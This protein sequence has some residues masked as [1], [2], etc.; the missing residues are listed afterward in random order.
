M[1]VPKQCQYT[2]TI[3]YHAATVAKDDCNSISHTT[4]SSYNVAFTLL[5]LRLGVYCLPPPEIRWFFI[6]SNQQC[7]IEVRLCGVG[8]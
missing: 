1:T 6:T 4:Y 7:A 8:N 5:P 2:Q 3:E